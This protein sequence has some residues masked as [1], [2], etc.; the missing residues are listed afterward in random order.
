MSVLVEFEEGLNIVSGRISGDLTREV[1]K[2]YLAKV[3]ELAAQRRCERVL[4]D[5]RN[6]S[7]TA[8]EEDMQCLSK[9]LAQIGLSSSYRRAIVLSEDVSGYKSWENHCLTVGH[10]NLK[11]FVD[12]DLAKE[13]LSEC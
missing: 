13:W 12:C 4:T 5:V 2:N 3:G 6:A 7:L 10:K 11:L 8:T 9:E 1:A